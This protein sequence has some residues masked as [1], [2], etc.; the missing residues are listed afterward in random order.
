MRPT[1][2]MSPIL[3]IPDDGAEDDRRTIIDQ[4]DEAIA[5][6]PS[7]RRIGPD[8]SS[9]TDADSLAPEIQVRV[10]PSRR[11]T[12]YQG[13]PTGAAAETAPASRR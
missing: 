9:N 1:F 2:L 12:M 8:V 6:G 3:A 5:S 4:P 13:P 10:E 11:L 7:P